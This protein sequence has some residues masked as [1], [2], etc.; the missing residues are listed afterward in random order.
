MV[1]NKGKIN[2]GERTKMAILTAKNDRM[3]CLSEKK[4]D[5]FLK[6]K[7]NTDKEK[8]NSILSVISKNTKFKDG[9]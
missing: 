8:V 9:K 5:K 2:K 3:F 6:Q 1:G 4:A 7:N